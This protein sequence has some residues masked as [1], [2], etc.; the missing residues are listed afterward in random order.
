MIIRID[1]PELPFDFDYSGAYRVP[2][3]NEYYLNGDGIVSR[4]SG[5]ALT[6]M[7]P[8]LVKRERASP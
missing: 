7:H 4:H 1:M 6:I 5:G 8:I 2:R 3:L